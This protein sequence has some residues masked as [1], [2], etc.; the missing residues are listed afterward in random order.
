[1]Y[2]RVQKL[3]LIHGYEKVRQFLFQNA[4]SCNWGC[5]IT[6]AIYVKLNEGRVLA[7]ARFSCLFKA[8]SGWLIACVWRCC[9]LRWH[10]SKLRWQ[11]LM[12]RW[13][14]EAPTT[15]KK[16]PLKG[17]ELCFIFQKTLVNFYS[18][19]FAYLRTYYAHT[20]ICGSV[21]KLLNRQSSFTSRFNK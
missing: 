3:K 4:C 9:C 21:M 17:T 20:L 12:V 14:A 7:Q 6:A 15:Q 18:S 2:I 5:F 16:G 10:R 11:E 8:A 13:L 1:M 19:Y